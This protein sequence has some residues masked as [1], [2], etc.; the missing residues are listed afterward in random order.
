[1]TYIRSSFLPQYS[2]IISSRLLFIVH[3]P[4][5]KI[6]QTYIHSTHVKYI[7]YFLYPR[8]CA[9]LPPDFC[10]T[11]WENPQGTIDHAIRSVKNRRNSRAQNFEGLLGCV[12]DAK[13]KD[14]G[15]KGYKGNKV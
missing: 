15:S 7:C 10:I 14:L 2:S 11:F 3:R 5:S 9:H 13:Y 4:A 8:L 6:H 12:G 1:M